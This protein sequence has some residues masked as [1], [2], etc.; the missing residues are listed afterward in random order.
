MK[1]NIWKLLLAALVVPA[2]MGACTDE[3]NNFMVDD[4]VS[5][6]DSDGT[7]AE[8]KGYVSTA[9]YNEKYEFPVVKN[10]KG[11]SGTTVR[12]EASES[13]LDAFNEANGTNYE[14]LPSNCY[15]FTAT[16]LRFSEK[17]V[18]K[19]AGLTWKMSDVTALDAYTD[20]VIPIQ[21]TS[22]SNDVPVS[23]DRGLMLLHLEIAKVSMEL[24]TDEATT[25]KNGTFIY[26]GNVKLS[27]TVPTMDVE[28]KYAVDTDASLVDAYNKANGTSYL[29]APAG[30]ASTV[31]ASSVI[32]AG[33]SSAAFGCQ[34][35]PDKLLENV[36]KLDAGV[37]IPVRI[38]AVSDG[39][40]I[41]KG[42]DV[43][44]IPVVNKEFRGTDAEPWAILEGEEICYANDPGRDPNAAWING[45]VTSNLF[46]GASTG[47]DSW[48]PWWVT[49]NTY[50]ITIVAD[51]G[52]A[53]LVSY[54]KIEDTTDSQG[55]Y[56]DYEIYLAEEYNGD[57]TEWTLVAS[58]MRD[59]DGIYTPPGTVGVTKVYD[60]P[61]QKMAAGRYLKFVIVKCEPVALQNRG[62][63]GDVW[64]VG[65]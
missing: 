48:I 47:G 54:F 45:Y 64:G 31:A 55:A 29:A 58:G 22:S 62:K 2:A 12:I 37:L 59:W 26:N 35:N 63:L 61:V 6:V 25:V 4:S 14:L 36:D 3:R 38:S 19:F 51:M 15:Q 8:N 60:Y 43:V 11:L 33:E 57:K 20:Y 10:G 28:V 40:V 30:F 32:A 41:T 34:L 50:P 18:R 44:Y 23:E 7:W 16:E 56:L 9:V 39:T 42:G 27:T 46:N 17:E 21:L 53:H 5:F 52:A 49:P 24:S 13:A 1:I 65:L